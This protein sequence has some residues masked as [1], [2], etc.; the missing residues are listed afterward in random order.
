M[1]DTEHTST[2]QPL[3]LQVVATPTPLSH[4][5][6]MTPLR[7]VGAL[8]G[9]RGIAVGLV[10]AGHAGLVPGGGLGVDLF[11]ALSGFL[12][13]SLLVTEWSSADTI[14]LRAFYR[15]RAARLVPALLLMMAPFTLLLLATGHAW[16]LIQAAIGVAYVGNLVQAVA[17]QP[18][19]FSHLWSLAEEEQF[20]VLWPLIFVWLLRRGTQPR[21]V[22]AGLTA[23]ALLLITE[24]VGLA[25]AGVSLHRLWFAPDT[26]ADAILFGCTAAIARSFGLCRFPS[27]V[28]Y[29]GLIVIGAVVS[30]FTLHDRLLYVGPM[31]GFAAAS[32]LTVAGIA[33]NPESLLSRALRFR[34]LRGLGRVS[35][36]VY[37]WHIPLFLIAGPAAGS[38]LA[39]AFATT[40]Y[41]YVE[42]PLRDRWKARWQTRQTGILIGAPATAG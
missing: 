35:Y 6:G 31:A 18:Q 42:Q 20:Y 16:V 28:T 36:G 34:P 23:V 5:C 38:L 12:I 33:D 2:D 1:G 7:H 30:S 3:D 10:L 25:T 14:D 15:R 26:H 32:A 21:K 8:D 4:R 39:L 37:L 22:L 19:L 13:T 41:L 29:A 27:A 17:P 11:F 9:L 24:R 40:S